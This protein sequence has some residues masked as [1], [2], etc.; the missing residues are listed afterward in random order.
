VRETGEVRHP[1][2]VQQDDEVLGR[3]LP[4]LHDVILTSAKGDV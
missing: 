2:K 4:E 1:L 3:R